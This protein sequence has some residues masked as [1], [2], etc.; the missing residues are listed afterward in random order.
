MKK[1]ASGLLTLVLLAAIAWVSV[2]VWNSYMY[3]PWT[4]DGRVR[5]TV[6]NIAP[7][8]SGWLTSLN[9]QN[10]SNVRRGDLLFSV[11]ASRYQVALDLAKARAEAA[12]VD[13]KRSA[14]MLSRRQ[15]VL[16][17]GVS[18]EE[19]ELAKIDVAAKLAALDEAL[20][21]VRASEIDLERTTYRA[22]TSGKVINL[23]ME[24]G[25]YVARG[26]ERLAIV[27]TSSYYLTGYFEETKVPSIHVGDSV[28]VWLMAGK[29]ELK[30]HVRA[31]N[32]GISNENATPGNELLPRVEPTFTW[33]RL[34]QRIPVDIAIDVVPPDVDLTSGMSATLR[35]HPRAGMLAE[36]RSAG[37][38]V[39]SDIK[40]AMQ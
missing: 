12:R 28:D 19:T 13:W 39:E 33:L 10:G 36:G 2:R 11:D 24:K 21:N 26:V 18:E 9:A 31:V 20:A 29:V 6:I 8:V 23:S 27:D 25:D 7:D 15:R 14:S 16:E 35:V 32:A 22:P 5:S 3:T 40:A 34:A 4:R 38:A 17:G 30:G 37:H 1:L